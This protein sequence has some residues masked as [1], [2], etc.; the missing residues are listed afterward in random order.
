MVLP[1]RDAQISLGACRIIASGVQLLRQSYRES[2]PQKATTAACAASYR[3]LRAK[4]SILAGG[5]IGEFVIKTTSRRKV[6]THALF[7]LSDQE[8]LCHRRIAD[9]LRD[10]V[11]EVRAAV[12]LSD[13]SQS[14]PPSY[15]SIFLWLVLSSSD[16]ET[17]P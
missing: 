10:V 6:S 3:L 13:L 17:C 14:R 4:S 15:R 1:R 12:S 2:S 8:D 16:P 5:G 11:D 9:S 7:P